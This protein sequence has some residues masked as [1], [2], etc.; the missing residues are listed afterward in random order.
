MSGDIQTLSSGVVAGQV[1]GITSG[2]APA[3]GKL[4]ELIVQNTVA[5]S[6][7]SLTTATTANVASV[8]VSAGEWDFWGTITFNLTGAT[9]TLLTGGGSTTS[10]TLP[11]QPGSGG[12]GPD[13]LVNE[14]I[15]TTTLTG[16]ITRAFFSNL[17][18][19]STTQL[20]LVAQATFSVGTISAYGSI[21]FRRV[22]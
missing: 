10:A 16:L 1:P 20:F 19:A 11:L 2:G 3:S 17:R 8:F 14:S 12:I 13:A 15:P 4:G 22:G 21:N 9:D 5:G 7:V 18:I 6:A